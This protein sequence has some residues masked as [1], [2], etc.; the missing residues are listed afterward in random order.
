MVNNI[1]IYVDN[2]TLVMSSIARVFLVFLSLILKTYFNTSFI[3][4][5]SSAVICLVDSS[6]V[7]S[8]SCLVASSV[9]PSLAVVL[10]SSH[11]VVLVDCLQFQNDECSLLRSTFWRNMHV[12]WH[13]YLPAIGIGSEIRS[14]NR[15][16][17]SPITSL[18]GSCDGLFWLSCF[19]FYT[20]KN[21]CQ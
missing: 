10:V 4:T 3:V 20:P 17:A 1:T 12:Y 7:G 11:L 15:L 16:I 6:L 9:R 13:A 21:P 5:V 2:K 19:S 8:R 14:P 18:L